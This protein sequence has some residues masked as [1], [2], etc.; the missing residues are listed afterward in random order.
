MFLKQMEIVVDEDKIHVD[1]Q[2]V[3]MERK[4][5]KKWAYILHD[6]DDT[7]NHYHIY[8]N[9]GNS[10]VNTADVAKWFELGYTKDG[11]DY[12]G[13]QFI[14]KVKGRYT[15]M[16]LY[17]THGNDSQQ[18]KYQ[19]SPDEARA[20]FDFQT[21]IE[22]AKN[23]GNFEKYSYAQQLQYVSKRIRQKVQKQ[24]KNTAIYVFSRVLRTKG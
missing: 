4:T 24:V 22:N 11:K 16:L 8:I 13:E 3:C 17:L 12:T 1:I 19:Y 14:E 21:E 15:D 6:K 5:I 2:K 7:R 10:S 18:N 23:L 9:F 20:N